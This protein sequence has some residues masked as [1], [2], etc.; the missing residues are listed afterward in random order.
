MNSEL[1][2]NIGIGRAICRLGVKIDEQ[3]CGA[4]V[5]FPR[6]FEVFNEKMYVGV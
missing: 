2:V 3:G 6:Q 1:S 4:Q 5:E